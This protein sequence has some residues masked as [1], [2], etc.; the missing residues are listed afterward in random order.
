MKTSRKEITRL[1]F[2]K[3]WN[4]YIE[5]VPYAK[6]YADLVSKK[7]GKI[8]IDHIAFRTFNAHTGEQP[9]GIRA[10]RHLLNY[11]D[12]QPVSK[13]QFSKKKLNAYHFEHPDEMFPKIFVSQLEVNE[14]PEWA[15]NI[16]SNAVKNT[17][18]LISDRSISLLRTL[19]EQ[20][21][22]PLEAAD[23]LVND[24]VHYFRRPWGIPL[25]EDVLK[26]N[27]VSQYGAWVLLHGNSVNHFAA[28]INYQD[29][30]EWPDLEE[31]CKGLAQAG[32]PMKDEIE[33]EKGSKL[34]QSATHAVKEEVKVKSDGGIEKIT[35]TSAYLELTE[36]NFIEEN[37][38]SKL[39]TGFLGAQATHLFDMTQTHDN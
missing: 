32:I 9:E 13:Y 17:P 39:F 11:L 26:I 37:G 35:W 4:N 2:D 8:A 23:F 3:L 7:G 30:K 16:I 24:L 19:E 34:R 14:L 10:I 36:R 18:Y 12:Y 21:A 31:T 28:F 6:T 38:T 33:G 22:L 15:Q 5:R 27:D 1:L 25:K 20:G 29:V